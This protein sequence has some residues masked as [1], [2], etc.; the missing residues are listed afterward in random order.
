[1]PATRPVRTLAQGPDYF[2]AQFP[3]ETFP[4]YG[5]D[6]LPAGLP[7]EV[8]TTETTHRDGQQGGLPLST[9]QSIRIY[10]I[11]C[12]FTRN[13]GAIR[14]AEFFVYR[15][16]DLDALREAQRRCQSGHPIEPTTWQPRSRGRKTFSP[17]TRVRGSARYLRGTHSR[18]FGVTSIS[19]S[20]TAS[21]SPES[22]MWAM[23]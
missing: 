12:R 23:T 15:R 21:R 17:D 5:W 2:E 3:R 20:K 22:K 11:L 9:E 16:S 13:S 18:T 14:Q 19:A 7:T 6:R 1:M 8:W 10:E 4:L